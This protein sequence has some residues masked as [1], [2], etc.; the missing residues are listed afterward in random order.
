VSTGTTER[1]DG[2]PRAIELGGQRVDLIEREHLVG[3]VEAALDGRRAPIWLASAN[4]DHVYRFADE[5]DL[6]SS[7]PEGQWLVVLDGMPLVWATRRRTGGSW[8]QLAGSDLLPELLTRAEA[9]GDRVGFLGGSDE[10]AR[11]LPPALAERWP[12]LVVAGHWTPPREVVVDPVASELLAG[13]IRNAGVDLLV[14][15]LGKPRQEH[16]IARHGAGTGAKV[17]AAFGASTEFIAG[18]QRRCPPM[19][20]KLGCE[21]LY[22]LGKEPRRMARRYLAE[23]PVALAKVV[24]HAEVTHR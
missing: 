13:D 15:G 20:T 10:L 16:W 14:V 18:V 11:L 22:R 4:L 19:F 23:G 12:K 21:W 1:R 8:E 5:P 6:F 9:R 2:R 7:R 17:A 3:A 24:R